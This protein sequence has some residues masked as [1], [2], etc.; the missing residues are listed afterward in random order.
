[1]KK[2]Y[3]ILCFFFCFFIFKTDVFAEI[4]YDITNINVD[5]DSLTLSGWGRIRKRD[6]GRNGLNGNYLYSPTY[7]FYLV[8]EGLSKSRDNTSSSRYVV[9]HYAGNSGFSLTESIYV[10]G[11]RQRAYGKNCDSNYTNCSAY[12]SDLEQFQSYRNRG[13]Y[14]YDNVDFN[15]T[16]DNLNGLETGHYRI[17]MEIEVP[18]FNSSGTYIGN[19][20]ESAGSLYIYENNG[21]N[22]ESSNLKV[23]N[24]TDWVIMSASDGNLQHL[25]YVNSVKGGKVATLKSYKNL[26]GHGAIFQDGKWY[27]VIDYMNEMV[28]YPYDDNV[29]YQAWSN[30]NNGGTKINNNV[31]YSGYAIRLDG[32]YTCTTSGCKSYFQY[33]DFAW[34]ASEWVR[35]IGD[36]YVTIEKLDPCADP[37]YT[38]NHTDECCNRSDLENGSSYPEMCCSNIEHQNN[39]CSGSNSNE[40]YCQVCCYESY[41]IV[42]NNTNPIQTFYLNT[43]RSL[44]SPLQYQTLISER[45]ST[46]QTCQNANEFY[47]DYENGTASTCCIENPESI[48]Q[49][50]CEKQTGGSGGNSC[51]TSSYFNSHKS[52]C[53]SL[54][55]YKNTEACIDAPQEEWSNPSNLSCGTTPPNTNAFATSGDGV[56]TENVKTTEQVYMTN[57]ETLSTM[58][59]NPVTAGT[60]FDYNV[61]IKHQITS[62]YTG[63]TTIDLGEIDTDEYST[64]IETEKNSI[65][66]SISRDT[67]VDKQNLNTLI[68]TK[69]YTFVGTSS[70]ISDKYV[71]DGSI[72]N[73]PITEQTTTFT[74]T[75]AY[76]DRWGTTRNKT[77]TETITTSYTYTYTYNLKLE[78]KY[79]AKQDATIATNITAENEQKNY[80][81]GGY[82][83][84]TELNTSTGIYD[85][86]ITISNGG[87]TG[88][89]SSTEEGFSCQYGVVNKNSKS[90]KTCLSPCSDDDYES[91]Y[92]YFRQ[93]SLNNPFPNRSAGRN[94]IKY[95][96]GSSYKY[97]TV[98]EDNEEKLDKVYG[99]VLYSIKLDNTK[100]SEIK[101]Y[102]KQMN[103]LNIGYAWYNMK[104]EEYNALDSTSN[105]L[106]EIGVTFGD[107]INHNRSVKIGDFE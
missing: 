18:T 77:K 50:Q 36:A 30:A 41:R 23:S 19:Y 49:S 104:Q 96:N 58:K 21:S 42:Y 2:I 40:W 59:E 98:D 14:F 70:N 8:K 52:S 25:E 22:L 16:F 63:S 69:P 84:Y 38:Y 43:F 51:S 89:L 86:N 95:K 56:T 97:I 31:H 71:L 65:K 9:Y 88:K 6:N 107:L 73:S 66:A 33:V 32:K 64:L 29:S 37:D 35:P 53:C 94:W 15:I 28:S 20:I 13:Q 81:D 26:V 10:K 45:C 47:Y 78:Q 7:H 60:G 57:Y 90:N 34:T 103:N 74:V 106:D 102:N 92:Y 3:L 5:G 72:S 99:E 12:D 79:I 85:F 24:L 55:E 54:D 39:Y 67:A 62:S 61:S 68:N 75:Y 91:E 11:G 76:T 48:Y 87:I 1:M 93:I 4:T 80:L 44:N 105:F 17:E 83:Y 100:I 82:K 46:T 101:Q 27:Q